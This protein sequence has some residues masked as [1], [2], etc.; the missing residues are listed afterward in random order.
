[1]GFLLQCRPVLILFYLNITVVLIDLIDVDDG[2][3]DRDVAHMRRGAHKWSL[4]TYLRSACYQN[5][6][7]KSQR[8]KK[9]QARL[10]I[11]CRV[12]NPYPRVYCSF[13]FENHKHLAKV[14]VVSV[15]RFFIY[16]LHGFS[17]GFFIFLI[18]CHQR[19]SLKVITNL[20]FY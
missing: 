5:L 2:G 19:F 6:R 7:W 14:S 8:I 15:H 10:Q 9:P 1:M 18:V 11:F 3:A 17:Y 12:F 4:Q 13:L 16:I 20:K